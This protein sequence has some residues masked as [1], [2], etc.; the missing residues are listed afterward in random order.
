MKDNRFLLAMVGIIL[1]TAIA[2]SLKN[3]SD[4]WH[5]KAWVKKRL[6]RPIEMHDNNILHS[7]S[8]PEES[9]EH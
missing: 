4:D 2:C 7:N 6:E 3:C 5:E 9:C 1:I 8:G